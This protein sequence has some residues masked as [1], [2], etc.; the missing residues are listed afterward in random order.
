MLNASGQIPEAYHV[1]DELVYGRGYPHTAAEH[2]KVLRI[3]AD[4]AKEW[5]K[6]RQSNERALTP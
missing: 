1:M 5:N 2:R 4:A 3:P 6:E